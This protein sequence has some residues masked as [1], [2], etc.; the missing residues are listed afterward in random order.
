M[1]KF[2]K[3]SFADMKNMRWP[4]KKNI[5]KNTVVSIVTAVMISVVTA[6]IGVGVE[7]ALSLF[8]N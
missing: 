5:V 1:M 8:I 7:Y 6:G 2:V 4:S 3:T